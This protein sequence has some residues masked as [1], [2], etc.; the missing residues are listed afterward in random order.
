MTFILQAFLFCHI[1]A[2]ISGCGNDEP[3]DIPKPPTPKPIDELVADKIY[4]W[5]K[6]R[7]AIP[8]ST[9]MVL[10]YG[11]GHHRSP[12]EWGKERIVDYV[13]YTD[14]TGNKHWL[15]DSF[16]FLEILDP[17]PYGANKKF[18][19]GYTYNN[20]P[21]VS[22]DKQDWL[23]LIDYYFQNDTGVGALE[24]SVGEGAVSLGAPPYKRQ[25]VMSI[26]EPIVYHTVE[27]KST[28]YWGE[29]DGKALDF[30]KSEDRAKACQWFID[31]VR[32]R[33]DA[34]KYKNIE[35]A[36]FYW[37]AEKATDTRAILNTVAEYLDGLKYS[38]NWI[39]FYTADGYSQWKSF[40][41]HYA[42]LQPNYFF[43]ETIPY[44]RLDE[45]CNMAKTS[46]MH[47]ELEFDDNALK[48]RGRGYRL[49]DYMKAFKNNGIWAEKRLAYYQGGQSLRMLKLSSDPVDKQLYH[50]FCQFVITRPIRPAE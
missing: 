3:R 39:P 32:A 25:I 27:Q 34:K 17:G 29:V 44:S 13:L 40:G 5:E 28:V 23:K 24:S 38:F 1:A 2:A 8:A 49:E 46:N 48:S 15:F 47:M 33:F 42:Y 50:D 26:P 10:M 43:S 12:Y 4:D 14:Q 30:S 37:L 9:D 21:L 11:G 20:A 22:A 36:G 45:A 19:N 6:A 18:A 7:T 35:L 41:F 31:Q 16:L